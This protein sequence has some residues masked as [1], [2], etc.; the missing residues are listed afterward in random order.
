MWYRSIP[1]GHTKQCMLDNP[2]NGG[3]S[4]MNTPPDMTTHHP[5]HPIH[6]THGYLLSVNSQWVVNKWKVGENR[7]Q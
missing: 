6:F 2:A 3:F 4:P 7:G 1:S 5:K